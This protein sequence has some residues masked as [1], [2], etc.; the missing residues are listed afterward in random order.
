[1]HLATIIGNYVVFTKQQNL[2][3]ALKTAPTI[4]DTVGIIYKVQ[5]LRA[6]KFLLI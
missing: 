4:I 5:F 2:L 1:M 6:I 3:I